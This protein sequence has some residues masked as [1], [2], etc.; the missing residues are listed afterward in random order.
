MQVAIFSK[1]VTTLHGPAIALARTHNTVPTGNFDSVTVPLSARPLLTDPL[2]CQALA[3]RSRDVNVTAQAKHILKTEFLG[4][5]LNHR[6]IANQATL[7]SCSGLAGSSPIEQYRSSLEIRP[8]SSHPICPRRWRRRI[9]RQPCLQGAG[10]Q[11]V[12]AGGV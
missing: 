5:A 12:P 7:P 11:R 2:R 9:H 3:L 10:R 8:L 6:T 4:Q 1:L